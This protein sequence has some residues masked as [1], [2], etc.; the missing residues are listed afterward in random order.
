MRPVTRLRARPV[1]AATVLVGLAGASLFGLTHRVALVPAVSAVMAVIVADIRMPGADGLEVTRTLAG[2]HV[3]DPIRVIVVSGQTDLAEAI[4]AIGDYA[5][6]ADAASRGQ[7]RPGTANLTATGAALPLL[8]QWFA[9]RLWG[10]S[11]SR[12]TTGWL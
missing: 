9:P 7:H 5:V 6:G 4:V 1:S 11:R 12:G 2:P 10:A 8:P 3:A